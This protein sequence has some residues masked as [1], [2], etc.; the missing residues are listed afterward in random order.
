[1]VENRPVKYE[2]D[3][4]TQG[5]CK[6]QG[7]RGSDLRTEPQRTPGKGG[8]PRGTLSMTTGE[9][10]GDGVSSE[11]PDDVRAVCTAQR[12]EGRGG[13]GGGLNRR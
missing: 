9:A 10:G 3:E 2:G 4:A 7:R 1:M 12:P 8:D 6:G 13:L 11:F 5:E